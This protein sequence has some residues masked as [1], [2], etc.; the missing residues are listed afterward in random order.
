[1]I[2]NGVDIDHLQRVIGGGSLHFPPEVFDGVLLFAVVP[3]LP[4]GLRVP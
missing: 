1:V 3:V 4:R 2:I